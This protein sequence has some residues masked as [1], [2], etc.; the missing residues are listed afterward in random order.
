MRQRILPA[1][2]LQILERDGQTTRAKIAEELKCSSVT[3]SHKVAK[4]IKDGENIG[5]GKDGL[6]IYGREDMAD[7]TSA[8]QAWKWGN[9]IVNSLQM[10]AQRGNNTRPILL[11]ARRRWG[12]ELTRDERMQLRSNLLLMTRVVD[13]V[14]LDEELQP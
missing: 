1:D 11:E 4:L 2:V 10:W 9:R 3:V 12:K 6:F 13:A 5:F 7:Q 8:E 14:N